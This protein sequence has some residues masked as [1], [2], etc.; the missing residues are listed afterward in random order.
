MKSHK[1]LLLTFLFLYLVITLMPAAVWVCQNPAT[2]ES[3]SPAPS[4]TAAPS[5]SPAPTTATPQTF[6][7]QDRATGETLTVSEREFLMGTLACEMDLQSPAESLKAQTV[8]AYT[9]YAYQRMHNAPIECDTGNWLVYVPETAM[10]ARW[11]ENYDAHATVLAGVV[12]AVLGQ[13][14]TYQGE[15]ALT[16]YFAISPGS[17]E[18]A[19]HVWAPDAWEEHPYLQ[20]V[21]S[22]GDAFSDGYLSTADFSLEEFREAALEIAGE[23]LDGPVEDWLTDVTYT[24]SHMV[25][26]ALLGGTTVTGTQLRAAFGLRSASFTVALDEEGFHFT[27]RGWG[28]GVGMSQAGAVFLAKRGANY[29]E[30]LAHYY[31][32]TQLVLPGS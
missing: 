31:P 17:T 5:P 3:P 13:T 25:K 20:A 19:A 11:G 22:P 7:L 2:G 12:D 28:H 14:L 6:T 23:G 30:I 18:A 26:S 8:A 4:P 16:S 27:V 24:P 15:L 29:Q 32:G 9:Y 21:A 10:R 1:A